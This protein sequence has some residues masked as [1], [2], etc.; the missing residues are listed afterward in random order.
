MK[1]MFKKT[2]I[3]TSILGTMIASSNAQA[4]RWC[5][6][7]ICP[8]DLVYDSVRDSAEIHLQN[9]RDNFLENMLLPVLAEQMKQQ[10]SL[11]GQQM[12]G[13]FQTSMQEVSKKTNVIT[14][15]HNMR[16]LADLKP[17]PEEACAILTW[18]DYISSDSQQVANN[19][20][21]KEA[22]M[23]A[24]RA[25]RGESSSISSIISRQFRQLHN[26]DSDDERSVYGLDLLYEQDTINQQTAEQALLRIDLLTN[27]ESRINPIMQIQ[28]SDSYRSEYVE[29][30]RRALVYNL[31]KQH[32]SDPVTERLGA[33]NSTATLEEAYENNHGLV[34]VDDITPE[35]RAE[36][37]FLRNIADNLSNNESIEEDD[38]DTSFSPPSGT[39]GVVTQFKSPIPGARVSSHFNPGRVHPVHGTVRAH[40][41]VDFAVPIGTPIAAPYPGTITTARMDASGFGGFVV[42][43]HGN[44]VQSWYGHLD[45]WPNNISVGS[46]VEQGDI[47][48]LSGNTGTSTGPHLHYEIRVD[49]SPINPVGRFGVSNLE[50]SEQ[51]LG[52][53]LGTH[54]FDQHGTGQLDNQGQRDPHISSETIRRELITEGL[55]LERAMQ[56]YRELEKLR[57]IIALDSLNQFN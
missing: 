32:L 6:T 21:S 8:G 56:R 29:N 41:G 27:T 20:L 33:S 57:F 2:L 28:E 36:N 34:S 30:A 16:M 3:A 49:G 54:R 42:V 39:E 31:I 11:M 1:R 26:I 23:T 25:V 50:A 17:M 48:A 43:D 24:S 5:G 51:M 18:Q 45:G 14:D 47:I 53:M 15:L 12:L 38:G 13:G 19:L 55:S 40:R 9:I 7:P 22:A 46:S 4:V 35:E 52:Q 44:G 37:S 10:F